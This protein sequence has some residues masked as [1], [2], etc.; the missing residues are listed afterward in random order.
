MTVKYDLHYKNK[1][2]YFIKKNFEPSIN[3]INSVVFDCD[4]VLIDCKKS[5]NRNIGLTINK[6]FKLL[7]SNDIPVKSIP[8]SLIDN[9]RMSGGFNNDWNTTYILSLKILSLSSKDFLENFSN[10]LKIANTN[11]VNDPYD[12]IS[13][14]REE[15]KPFK[16]KFSNKNIMNI[17]KKLFSF[18]KQ[19]DESGLKGA[20]NKIF[21]DPNVD[22]NA[23]YQFK[24]FLCHPGTF[25]NNIVA[26]LFDELFYGSKL[27]YKIHNI[28]RKFTN[29]NGSIDSEKILLDKKQ[30]NS[31]VKL[32]GKKNIGIASGRGSVGAFYT[33]KGFK[34]Y[35]NP[36]AC[37][38][39]E[40]MY[41]QQLKNKS[42]G[43]PSPY[44]LLTVSKSLSK[45]GKILYV[46]DSAEDILMTQKAN[47]KSNRFVFAAIY[48]DS[49]INKKD[50]VFQSLGADIIVK[51]VNDLLHLI[52]DYYALR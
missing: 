46:G 25:D 18:S 36:D 28:P 51:N 15:I 9:I 45:K 23:L 3:K 52:G 42:I 16:D 2:K 43:K 29:V 49:K 50:Q 14:V 8:T 19:L 32:F 12:R 7:T 11:H 31:T 10:I 39:L 41:E 34:K 22:T 5:Y 6:L 21:S 44:S 4:G 1:S 24:K 33:L 40:D 26:I 27:Y 35:F 37:I 48:G 20:E 17:D 47:K 38:F 13:H 30:L